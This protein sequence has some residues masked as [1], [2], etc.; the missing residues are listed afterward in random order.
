M[1]RIQET[2]REAWEKSASAAAA[3]WY[4]ASGR[5]QQVLAGETMSKPGVRCAVIS[6]AAMLCTAG[7]GYGAYRVAYGHRPAHTTD[8]AAS[9]PGKVSKLLEEDTAAA[10]AAASAE[11]GAESASA[12]KTASSQKSKSRQAPK[13]RALPPAMPAPVP[14]QARNAASAPQLSLQTPLPAP[15]EEFIVDEMAIAPAAKQESSKPAPKR[16]AKAATKTAPKAAPQTAQL[17]TQEPAQEPAQAMTQEPAQAITPEPEQTT[18]PMVAQTTAPKTAADTRKQAM[19][20]Q[21]AGKVQAAPAMIHA[22]ALVTADERRV[23]V[24]APKVNGWI[25]K[26]HAN[27]TGQEIKRGDAL[28]DTY[29]PEFEVLQ[30]RYQ[31]HPSAPALARLSKL[32]IADR[33][34]EHLRRTRKPSR[35]LT[36]RSPVGGVILEKKAVRGLHFSKG[37]ELYRIADLSSVWV[38][39]YI[40][41]KKA[42]AVKAGQAATVTF[43]AYPSRRFHAKV[44]YVYPTADTPSHTVPVRLQLPN[45]GMLLKPGMR[46]DVSIAAKNGKSKDK[47][48][49]AAPP[50]QESSSPRK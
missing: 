29:S 31:Q 49:D 44:A 28:F 15:E 25:D 36:L 33:D 38:I 48:K 39:A 27:T 13:P 30:K 50:S 9:A 23:F 32:D 4:G 46:A 21:A 24:V 6:V 1:K 7:I 10:A 3:L 2:C 34:L 14:M 35:T 12:S 22:V 47:G 41:E 26:L 45:E 43:G 17:T 42:S 40:P 11:P 19:P 8:Q 37:E 16:T 5:L 18:R 20:A